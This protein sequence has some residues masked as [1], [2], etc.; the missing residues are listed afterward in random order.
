[1]QAE[2]T[3][4]RLV[5][6]ERLD[7]ILLCFTKI[8]GVSSFIVSP[9]GRPISEEYNWSRLCSDYCR[10]TEKGRRLCYES[11]RHGAEMSVRIKKRY[12]YT[13]LNAG[14]VDCTF[15]IIVGNYHIASVM[16]G[17][18]LHGPIDDTTAL[19]HADRIGIKDKSGYLRALKNVPIISHDMLNAIV[20]FMEVVTKTISDLAWN[21]YVST[22]QSRR[23]LD[24]IVNLVSD[25][26]ISIDARGRISMVNDAF[27]KTIGFK[28]D[29]IIG[30]LFSDHISDADSL[31]VYRKTLDD[32]TE[33]GHG[34]ALLT[35]N[36]ADNRKIP[37]QVSFD[38]DE[39]EQAKPSCVAVLRDISEEKGIES[40][41]EDLIGMMTH[42]LRN[43]IF[44]IQKALQLLGDGVIGTLTPEQTKLVHLS[45]RTTRQLSGMVMDYLDIYRHEDGKLRL[46]KEFLDMRG[47]IRTAVGQMELIAAEKDIVIRYQPDEEEQNV[48]ADRL[49][50]LR[51]C[52]NLLANAV[53]FSPVGGLV[54]IRIRT[55]FLGDG[56]LDRILATTARP[57]PSINDSHDQYLLT[58]IVDQGPGIEKGAEAI[59]FDKF[60]TLRHTDKNMGCGVGLGL[61]FC[62]LA[63]EAHQGLI[64][65]ASPA[66]EGG[67]DEQPGS[68]FYFILPADIHVSF[69][70]MGM[71][72]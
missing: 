18:V 13:C 62:K 7:E 34:R 9:D 68:R 35:L 51:I 67:G 50:M 47:I 46:R 10:S 53:N 59:I 66:S 57:Y 39:Y 15:P 28:K 19:K 31:K 43:P 69:D 55:L 23:H 48:M 33:T 2:H 61:A 27:A 11:D 49:R 3:L 25:G 30:G 56:E 8:T 4:L 65:V 5:E 32:V 40:L 54:D 38:K 20:D 22:K 70:S 63:V 29:G 64:G 45:E 41:K 58:E 52:L 44:S 6:K 21:K 1:M 36:G 72:F 60:S 71:K 16:C 26:I 42:D 37:V 24:R 12:C 17:Q 14:L